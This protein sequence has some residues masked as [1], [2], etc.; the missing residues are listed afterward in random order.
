MA[1]ATTR[2]VISSKAATHS[3]EATD[4][5]NTTAAADTSNLT[6]NNLPTR[7]RLANTTAD[8]EV[9]R[10]IL[11]KVAMTQHL[12][13]TNNTH[14]RHLILPTRAVTH[15]TKVTKTNAGEGDPEGERGIMGGIAGAAAGGYGGHTLG[16]KAGHGTAG[17]I[18]GALAGAFAGHKGQDAV[19]DKWDEHKDK[20]KEEEERKKWEEEE[21]RRKKYGQQH[22]AGGPP[23]S[24]H[25]DDSHSQRSAGN[26]GGNFSAS[27]RDIRLDAHGDYTLHAQCRRADGSYQASSISLNRYLSNSDG[28]FHWSGSSSERSGGNENTYTV[29]QG[30]T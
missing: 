3:K 5:M 8:K 24:Q 21:E 22:H 14:L 30:D 18:I 20:K 27:S 12:L 26:Y 15:T 9:I 6:I 11:S 2:V 7:A 28:S 23:P 16:G 19:E 10:A 4:R 25:H 17:T 29:Q 13:N 1:A